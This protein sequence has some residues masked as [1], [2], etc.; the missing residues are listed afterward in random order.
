MKKL[1]NSKETIVEDMLKGFAA[2]HKEIVELV[3]GTHI[4]KRRRPKDKTKVKFAIGNGA[5][6]EPAVIGWVGEGMFDMNIVGEI[7]TAPSAHQ[8]LQ[9]LELLNDG[10]DILLAVQNHAGDVMNAEMACEMAE[11][12]GIKVHP[13]LFYDDIASAPKGKEQERRGIGGMLFYAKIV[14]SFLDSGGGIEEAKRLFERVRD[15]TRT[16]AV[17]IT[18]CTHPITGLKMF[19]LADDEI[20]LG[21]G[22]H[23]EG[24]ANRVAMV[25]ARELAEIMC[26][27]IIEDLPYEPGDEV[28][29]LVNGAGGMTMMEM[30]IFYGDVR[31]VLTEK[32]LV[33]YAAK[34]G[35]YL[36][37]QELSGLSL[38]FCRV[39]DEMKRWWEAPCRVPFF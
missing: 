32:N 14:G 5:G 12:Q 18:N 1:I 10:S 26:N 35:N 38:S 2:A 3:P 19:D 30:S 20:E 6:H 23:G 8:I 29:I 36:T 9:G 39:D 16:Y 15:N 31:D 28:L 24:G 4:I 22:V 21:M 37:T 27:E 13:V 7:F 33:P 17:A 11:E 25:S 34:V